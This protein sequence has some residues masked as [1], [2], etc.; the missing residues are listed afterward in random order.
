MVVIRNADG[1]IAA[2]V[3]VDLSM[4]DGDE[5]DK[6]S[7]DTLVY[8]G[9]GEFKPNG[10]YRPA[11]VGEPTPDANGNV[12]MSNATTTYRSVKMVVIPSTDDTVADSVYV[13]RVC[14]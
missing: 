11:T 12:L 10:F 8:A 9:S 5:L 4:N 13:V 14:W 7:D 1:K 3:Y 6:D 2:F